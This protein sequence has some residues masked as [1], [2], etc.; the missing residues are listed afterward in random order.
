MCYLM[1]R[2]FLFKTSDIANG[3]FAVHFV[4]NAFYNNTVTYLAASLRLFVMQ[5]RLSPQMAD[6]AMGEYKYQF[7]L[8]LILY[9]NKDCL[10]TK[11]NTSKHGTCFYILHPFYVIFLRLCISY[12]RLTQSHHNKKYWA[13]QLVKLKEN[14]QK[15]MCIFFHI[16]FKSSL[17]NIRVYYGV[18]YF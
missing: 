9:K 12:F 13:K 5:T 2:S 3:A 10:L 1:V 17:F 11:I 14:N 4:M 7:T 18:V 15:K 16:F 8:H 6:R